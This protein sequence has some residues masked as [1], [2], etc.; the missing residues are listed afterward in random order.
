MALAEDADGIAG[1]VVHQLG[2]RQRCLE[3]LEEIITSDASTVISPC[4]VWKCSR[5]ELLRIQWIQADSGNVYTGM[6]LRLPTR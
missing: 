4:P 3:M 5:S 2:G 6:D 1:R